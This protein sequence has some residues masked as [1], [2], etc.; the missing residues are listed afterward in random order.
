VPALHLS[1]VTAG[2]GAGVVLGVVAV[3]QLARSLGRALR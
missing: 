3:V 1:V 2:T